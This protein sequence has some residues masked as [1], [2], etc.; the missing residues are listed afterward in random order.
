M[1]CRVEI[2]FSPKI[3]D[4]RIFVREI[5]DRNSAVPASARAMVLSAHCEEREMRWQSTLKQHVNCRL[6]NIEGLRDKVKGDSTNQMKER[7][8]RQK[9]LLGIVGWL[10]IL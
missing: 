10:E 8:Y 5:L 7:L 4:G 6:K 1:F 2:I 9:V 3:I